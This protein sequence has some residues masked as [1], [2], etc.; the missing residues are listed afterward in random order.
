MSYVATCAVETRGS[1]CDAPTQNFLCDSHRDDL[2]GYLWE[3]GGLKIGD[4][5][6]YLP[7]LLD[8]LDTTICGDDKVGGTSIGVAVQ[9]A[10]TP[11]MFNERASDAKLHLC[12]SLVGWTRVFAEENPHLIFDVATIEDAARWL[13]G[14]P[15]LLAGH[16]AAVEMFHE[17]RERYETARRTVDRPTSRT[18][19]G[20]CVSLFLDKDT[21]K[22][23]VRPLF[24]PDH[25]THIQCSG[26]DALYDVAERQKEIEGRLRPVK[27]SARL[28]AD[29][30]RLAGVGINAKTIRTWGN[31]GWLTNH[32]RAGET[33]VHEIGQ[34]LDIARGIR[35]VSTCEE[36]A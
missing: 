8:E 25:R 11:L 26:C 18:Y 6:D 13:V 3:I 14:F 21:G 32:A 29:T 27:A 12:N 17:L 22:T 5:G 20:P 4:R 23:C 31:R 30:L 33:P 24:A 2:I 28:I 15:N 19:V 35:A 7:S 9:S 36:V 1:V 16:P 34:V 10:E